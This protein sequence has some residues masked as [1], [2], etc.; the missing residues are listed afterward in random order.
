MSRANAAV[1][2]Y[3]HKLVM[4]CGNHLFEA[5]NLSFETHLEQI[6]SSGEGTKVDHPDEFDFLV[7]FKHN[8]A[9]CS[10]EHSLHRSTNRRYSPKSYVSACLTNSQTADGNKIFLDPKEI[11]K[12]FHN[13]LLDRG[14]SAVDKSGPA[15]AVWLTSEDLGI[16][17]SDLG[18]KKVKIDLTLA[19][20]VD[21][22]QVRSC[23]QTA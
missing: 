17:E 10:I 21:I 9:R 22:E 1:R 16:T 5:E 15:H 12:K 11:N 2:E 20:E 6:G 7:V 19:F 23:L 18:C 14:I 8:F 13:S 4:D 3:V